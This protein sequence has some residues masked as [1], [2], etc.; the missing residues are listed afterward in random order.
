MFGFKVLLALSRRSSRFSDGLRYQCL[1]PKSWDPCL[2]C[3]CEQLRCIEASTCATR[4]WTAWQDIEKARKKAACRRHHD[5]RPRFVL[6]C[7][8]LWVPRK[9]GS[10]SWGW[11]GGGRRALASVAGQDEE[12]Q[13]LYEEARHGIETLEIFAGEYYA[14][15][16]MVT[17]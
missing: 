10:S 13:E 3:R 5:R 9:C 6:V 1:G 7:C 2:D 16:C 12:A 14:Q 8:E 11:R 15:G 4:L 17:S